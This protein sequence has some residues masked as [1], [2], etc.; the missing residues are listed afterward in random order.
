M[1]AEQGDPVLDE[2]VDEATAEVARQA[3][4][5]ERRRQGSR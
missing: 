3:D 4:E 5:I 2:A 1:I